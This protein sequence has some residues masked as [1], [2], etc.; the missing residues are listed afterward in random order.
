MS[1]YRIFEVLPGAL[2]WATL[3]LMV[4]FSWKL[5]TFVAV[6]VILFDLYWLFKTAYLTLHLRATFAAMKK[7]LAVDWASRLREECGAS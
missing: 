4:L 7:N 3:F 1:R 5:P 2:A 6:F